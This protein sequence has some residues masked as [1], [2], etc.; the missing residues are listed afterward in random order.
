[1]TQRR[2]PCMEAL[3][4]VLQRWID[5][6]GHKTP[7]QRALEA[8]GRFRSGASD[9]AEKH[10]AYLVAAILGETTGRDEPRTPVRGLDRRNPERILSEDGD[11]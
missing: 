11:T 1:M 5:G 4:R 3:Q 6:R 9:V 2:I 8:I 10:D 7:R